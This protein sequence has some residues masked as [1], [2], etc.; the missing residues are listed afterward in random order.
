[1]AAE[2]TALML[3]DAGD[4]VL[5]QRDLYGGTYRLI[6]SVLAGKGIRA[7]F[8]DLRDL[9]G[10]RRSINGTTKGIWIETPTNPLMNLVE[11]RAVAAVAQEDGLITICD[12]TFLSPY[13]QRPLEL[14]IDL[15]VHSTTKYING[16]SDVVGDAVM[17]SSAELGERVGYLQNA[18]G[19]CAAPADCSMVLRGIRTL[20]LR[21][22][23]HDRNALAIAHWLEA[24]ARVVRAAPRPRV[25]SAA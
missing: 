21:M 9:D 18:L 17:T 14:G 24:H 6:S 15:V 5:V 20:A 10:L 13:F 7:E 3:F 19:T 16:H 23:E 2:L 1:M 4:T 25:S 8:V 22:E 11:L 12:N